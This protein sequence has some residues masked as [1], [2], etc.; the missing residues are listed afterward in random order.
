MNNR[1]G[2]LSLSDIMYEIFLELNLDLPGRSK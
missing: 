2:E 1:P